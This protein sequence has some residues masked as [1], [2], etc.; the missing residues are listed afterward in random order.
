MMEMKKVVWILFV[1]VWVGCSDDSSDS[2]NSTNPNNANNGNNTTT[3][4]NINNLNNTTNPN[5]SNAELGDG[6]VNV[7]GAIQSEHTGV[8]EYIG[9]R[10]G[11]GFANLDL[12]VSEFPR[13]S[14]EENAFNFNIRMVG[15]GGPFVL[16]PG[17]YDIGEQDDGGPTIIVNYTNRVISDENMTYGTSPNSTGTVTITSVTST[18]IEATFDVVLFEDVTTDEGMVNVSGELTSTC[19]SMVGC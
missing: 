18:S 2:N 8:S 13:G 19:T 6:T 5:N 7:T 9:L 16:E 11:D 3:P 1:C 14:S 15:E 17:E 10:N 4:N 12:S